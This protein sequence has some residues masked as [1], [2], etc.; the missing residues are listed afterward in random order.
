MKYWLVTYFQ[1][2]DGSINNTVWIGGLVDFVLKHNQTHVVVL[3]N[4]FTITETEYNNFINL[5]E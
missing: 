4:A 3:I 2:D 1:L 5:G